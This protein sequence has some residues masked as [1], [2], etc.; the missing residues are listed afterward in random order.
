[1]PPLSLQTVDQAQFVDPPQ[2]RGHC[3]RIRPQRPPESQRHMR[4]HIVTCDP[5]SGCGEQAPAFLSQRVCLRMRL[6][7]C[8]HKWPRAPSLGA[9]GRQPVQSQVEGWKA[10]RCKCGPNRL[11]QFRLG[12]LPAP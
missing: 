7:T 8:Q 12:R 3:N 2:D 9:E 11:D 1:M 10:E 4:G 6:G 5:K